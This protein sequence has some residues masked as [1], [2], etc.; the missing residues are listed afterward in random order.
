VPSKSPTEADRKSL[1]LDNVFFE[2]LLY[3]RDLILFGPGKP[4]LV[5]VG[6]LLDQDEW[7][8]VREMELRTP[9]GTGIV[10]PELCPCFSTATERA[11]NLSCHWRL[12][13][14]SYT[15][16]KQDGGVPLTAINPSSVDVRGQQAEELIQRTIC[17]DGY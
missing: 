3:S 5:F 15:E 14:M 6:T 13:L 16:K 1:H 8:A 4:R 2:A 17:V 10:N 7:K 12:G 9:S 11:D